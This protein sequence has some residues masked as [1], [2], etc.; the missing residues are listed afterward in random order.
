MPAGKR[1]PFLSHHMS[2]SDVSRII[3]LGL[4]LL[5]FLVFNASPRY[6]VIYSYTIFKILNNIYSVIS[7]Y[8][9]E[10]QNLRFLIVHRLIVDSAGSVSN[11]NSDK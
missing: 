5:L 4:W 9:P 7:L 6:C 3:L 2:D 8:L 10:I 11:H 1:A